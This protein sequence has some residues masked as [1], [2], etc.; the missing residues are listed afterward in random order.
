MSCEFA[1]QREAKEPSG[2][3]ASTRMLPRQ[4]LILIML[5]RRYSS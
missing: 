3:M 5:A 1:A 4:L 2:I